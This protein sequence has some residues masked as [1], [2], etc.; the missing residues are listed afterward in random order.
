MIHSSIDWAAVA[1]SNSGF[2]FCTGVV[3][4]AADLFKGVILDVVDLVLL[5]GMDL[6]EYKRICLNSR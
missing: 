1:K 2:F 5:S 3:K 4:L 6:F